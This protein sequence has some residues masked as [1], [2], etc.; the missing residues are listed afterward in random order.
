MNSEIACDMP[1]D[2]VF[3]L[4]ASDSITT[5]QWIKE[6]NFVAT[7]I[8]SLH[9]HP[10][11]IH[12]GIIVF[13]TFIGDVVPLTPFKNKQ[14]LVQLAKSLKQPGFGTSTNLG[15][16]QLRKMMTLQGRRAEGTPQIAIVIT[17]GQS[18]YTEETIAQAKAAKDE[19]IIMIAVG[20]S[21]HAM[22][23]EL[24]SIASSRRKVFPVVDFNA[25]VG[26]VN[27]MRDL[28]CTG[29]YRNSYTR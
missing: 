3:L 12:V 13:S 7:L 6:R 15:I 17:D 5:K 9:I 24:E 28:I 25:L 27:I 2:I 16:A 11:T 10:S 23:R 4:D 20:I 14:L 18:D 22:T 19:G 8:N 26:L 29:G 1:A 21:P